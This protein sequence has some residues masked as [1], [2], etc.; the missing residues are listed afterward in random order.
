MRISS[1][2]IPEPADTLTVIATHL[3][4]LPL[5]M[6]ETKRAEVVRNLFQPML[7]IIEALQ[8]ATKA[9]PNE[10]AVVMR[11]IGAMHAQ[12]ELS[13]RNEHFLNLLDKLRMHRP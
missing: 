5:V 9:G 2:G 8:L 7:L 1:L 4:A 12:S 10:E 11:F 13:K 6:T 3:S